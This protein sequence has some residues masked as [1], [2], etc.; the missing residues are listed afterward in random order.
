MRINERFEVLYT[1]H[2][3]KIFERWRWRDWRPE[4]KKPSVFYGY[5]QLPTRDQTVGGGIVKCQDLAEVFPNILHS[6]SI[7]YLVSSALPYSVIPMVKYAKKKGVKVVLN[8][9]GVGYPGWAKEDWERINLPLRS[10]IHTADYVFYQSQFCKLSA[11]R[12]LGK[13]KAPYSILHNSVNTSFFT[14]AKIPPAGFRLLL[15]GSYHQFYRIQTAFEAFAKIRHSIREAKLILAGRYL[16]RQRRKML[17][18]KQ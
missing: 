10:V 12:Y 18:R 17:Y 9:N 15:A 3:P 2:C 5:G 7:L 14:P 6:A 11:D 13:I 1:L 8:Q 4:R 16:W